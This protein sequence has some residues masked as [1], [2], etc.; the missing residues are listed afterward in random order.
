MRRYYKY[1]I[2]C[3][4]ATIIA[5][6]TIT[7]VVVSSNIGFAELTPSFWIGYS[8]NM[9]SFIG[10]L[11]ASNIFFK[12]DTKDKI[13]F[14]LSIIQIAI[15]I[16]IVSLI[17]GIISMTVTAIPYWIGVVA[18][19]LILTIY[20]IAVTNAVA[21]VKIAESKSKQIKDETSFI[22]TLISEA[23]NLKISVI[24]EDIKKTANKIYEAIR[25]SDP[26]SNCNLKAINEEIKNEFEA[27]KNAVK[28]NDVELANAIAANL[29]AL[30]DK[31]NK[32]CLNS[33]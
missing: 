25:Y 16:L 24:N 31:R 10:N 5:F 29:L 13:F 26:V 3:W 28:D 12:K 9:L 17:A 7:F 23:E 19:V 33:K 20:C 30:I 27:F 2:T 18:D 14:N 32:Q 21:S 8:F 15:L 11:L 4:L 22:K 1:Y 6:N